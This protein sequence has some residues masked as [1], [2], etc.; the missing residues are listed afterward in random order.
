MKRAIIQSIS[1][2]KG[3]K[4]HLPPRKKNAPEKCLILRFVIPGIIPSKKNRQIP[5]INSSQIVSILKK[6]KSV[7]PEVI[8]KVTSIRPFIRNSEKFKKWSAEV[9]PDLVSQAQRWSKT[10]EKHQLIF[11]ITRCSISIYHYWADNK[12]RDNSNKQETIHDLLTEAG[13]IHDDTHQCLR[14]TE[15]EAENYHGEVTDHIT[16]ITISAFNW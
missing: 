2:G 12:R 7:T 1:T 3:D 15:S 16:V 4:I 11:P 14:K 8:K 10:Y 5:D 6:H 13:I 9:I